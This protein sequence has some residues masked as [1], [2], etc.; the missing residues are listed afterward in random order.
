MQRYSINIFDIINSL[1]NRVV[2][3]ILIINFF[4]NQF[5]KLLLKTRFYKNSMIQTSPYNTCSYS[6]IVWSHPDPTNQTYRCQ[7]KLINLLGECPRIAV[8]TT[9]NANFHANIFHLLIRVTQYMLHL[10]AHNVFVVVTLTT[11]ACVTRL[12]RVHG[13][14]L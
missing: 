8:D 10:H 4:I 7:V 13:C 11:N 5:Y 14:N 3:V 2:N 9:N 1:T 12:A 6:V